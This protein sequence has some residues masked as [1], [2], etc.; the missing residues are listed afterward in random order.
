MEEFVSKVPDSV[1][2]LKWNTFKP[3]LQNTI[4]F[5]TDV[6]EVYRKIKSFMIKHSISQK[7]LCNIVLGTLQAMF[8]V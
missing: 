7:H 8:Q 1:H 2:Q 4:Y 6:A 3:S 5:T